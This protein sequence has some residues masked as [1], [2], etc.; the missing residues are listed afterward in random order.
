MTVSTYFLQIGPYDRC[1]AGTNLTNNGHKA[2]TLLD[3][4]NNGSKSILVLLAQIEKLRVRR[5]AEGFFSELI[6]V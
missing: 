4:V 1:L 6:K 3:P 5:Q 2:L